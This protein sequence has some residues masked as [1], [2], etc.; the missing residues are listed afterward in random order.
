MRLILVVVALAVALTATAV[1]QA[2]AHTLE[3]SPGGTALV[4]PPP[5]QDYDAWPSLP[6]TSSDSSG[7][8]EPKRLLMFTVARPC[9]ATQAA[10]H[11]FEQVTKVSV[12]VT[13]HYEP[14]EEH[15]NGLGAW[16]GHGPTLHESSQSSAKPG[17]SADQESSAEEL[18]QKCLRQL[19]K[20]ST[21]PLIHD[22]QK[23]WSCLTACK[24]IAS[25]TMP[26]GGKEKLPSCSIAVSLPASWGHTLT[27][28]VSLSG[29]QEHVSPAMVNDELTLR[30]GVNKIKMHW[31]KNV[32]L[33]HKDCTMADW[34]KSINKWRVGVQKHP[35][36]ALAR[37]QES[38]R[39][40]E[41]T[42]KL[43]AATDTTHP[44][45]MLY[46]PEFQG[47]CSEDKILATLLVKHPPPTT[48]IRR[49]NCR[50]VTTLGRPADPIPQV[51]QQ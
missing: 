10:I 4:P 15:N 7:K 46:L 17:S 18:M 27:G 47:M 38:T 21:G 22:T 32:F 31:V 44:I 50:L 43:D 45:K 34:L 25:S 11:D 14:D 37:G 2:N 1:D 51:E 13:Y 35:A 42:F 3:S 39:S 48:A 6:E 23:T 5:A 30:V 33:E 29:T 24:F 16:G 49:G 41:S 28:W 19:V 8:N 26:T 40:D 20:V 9:A 12:S 36:Q